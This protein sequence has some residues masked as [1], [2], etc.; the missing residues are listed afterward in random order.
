MASS[1]V[2]LL[3]DLEVEVDN[4]AQGWKNGT[5]G[6]RRYLVGEWAHVGLKRDCGRA[7]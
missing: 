5:F 4:F 7:F 1:A 6:V 3:V 2:D